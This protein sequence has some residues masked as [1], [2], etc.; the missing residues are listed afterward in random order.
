MNDDLYDPT[1]QE[2][3]NPLWEFVRIANS[4]Y[5]P[6]E[7]S[8]STGLQ[9]RGSVAEKA[10][11][12]EVNSNAEL[13]MKAVALLCA[14][15]G[16]IFSK[17]GFDVGRYMEVFNFVT[18]SSLG[19]SI[20]TCAAHARQSV[21]FIPAFAASTRLPGFITAAANWCEKADKKRRWQD[22][23][24]E[25]WQKND[26]PLYDDY[27]FKKALHKAGDSTA[28]IEELYLILQKRKEAEKKREKRAKTPRHS[29]LKDQILR[30]WI[31]GALWARTPSGILQVLGV[32]NQSAAQVDRVTANISRLGLTAGR[33]KSV[34]EDEAI[35][36]TAEESFRKWID[37]KRVP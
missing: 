7:M 17:R 34:H 24:S 4:H 6:S 33:S 10:H 25:N 20:G 28:V 31:M 2:G 30:L 23:L 18:T 27:L 14:I 3:E 26:D 29:E 1:F 12:W 9:L 37:R 8:P 22:E 36:E 11:P 21:K 13:T 32:E 15:D 19:V 16:D 5:G 35:I